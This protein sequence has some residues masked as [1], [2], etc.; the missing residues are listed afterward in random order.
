MD[1][2]QKA[3]AGPVSNA[4]TFLFPS[5]VGTTDSSRGWLNVAHATVLMIVVVLVTS[6][7]L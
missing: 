5:P 3:P 6:L 1:E 7:E 4:C 2:L